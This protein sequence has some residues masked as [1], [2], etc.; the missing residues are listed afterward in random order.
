MSIRLTVDHIDPVQVLTQLMADLPAEWVE[1]ERA[2]KA[3]LD[4]PLPLA[5]DVIVL[6][7]EFPEIRTDVDQ[8][9]A[10]IAAAS[11]GGVEFAMSIAEAF[12]V[13]PEHWCDREIC[14]DDLRGD[15]AAGRLGE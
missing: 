4:G 5:G 13:C 14:M 6:L 1:S 2:V 3:L 10:T 9:D 8:L 12:E 11:R 7:L 15:C